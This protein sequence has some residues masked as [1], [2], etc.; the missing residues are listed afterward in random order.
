MRDTASGSLQETKLM[1]E[2]ADNSLLESKSM[3]EVAYK[4]FLAETSPK[5]F[6]QSI[7]PIRNLDFSSKSIEVSAKLRFKNVGKTIAKDFR[8]EYRSFAG[9]QL[10]KKGFTDLMPHLFPTQEVES[11]AEVVYT[12][13]LNDKDFAIAKEI[14]EGGKVLK[15]RKDA[16]APVSLEL[17]ISYLDQE[18]K[19]HKYSS[20]YRYTL[21]TN[22]WAYTSD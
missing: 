20:R 1:R 12:H 14:A 5:V 22:T 21:Y 11:V 4:S 2:I 17:D 9:G 6:L 15:F 3:R 10:I 13:P 16:G 19:K 7:R 18:D 8:A